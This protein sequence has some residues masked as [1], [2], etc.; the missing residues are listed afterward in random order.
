MGVDRASGLLRGDSHRLAGFL[1]PLGNL[2]VSGRPLYDA[3]LGPGAFDDGA[4]VVEA[5]D[6]L[7][8]VGNE[9]IGNLVDGVLVDPALTPFQVDL[10]LV[11]SG[12]LDDLEAWDLLDNFKGLEHTTTRGCGAHVDDRG[13]VGPA[14]GSFDEVGGLLSGLVD[15]VEQVIRIDVDLTGANTDEVV[16]GIDDT[17]RVG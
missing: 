17:K 7:D 16:V 2:A 13:A 11:K 8:N 10:L 14:H 12:G 9:Q 1:F 3:G 6:A 4:H 5:V 15:V